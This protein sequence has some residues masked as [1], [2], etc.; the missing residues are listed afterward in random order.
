VKSSRITNGKRPF[1]LM[2]GS[3]GGRKRLYMLRY[4]DSRCRKLSFCSKCD[5]VT[6]LFLTFTVVGFRRLR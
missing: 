6:A 3:G 1:T 2:Y 5:R 4:G